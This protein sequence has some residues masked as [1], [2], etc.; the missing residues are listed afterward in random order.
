M[1]MQ[2]PKIRIVLLCTCLAVLTPISHADKSLK[3]EYKHSGPRE[4]ARILKDQGDT[5]ETEYRDSGKRGN[6]TKS[7]HPGREHQKKS[8]KKSDT[9]GKVFRSPGQR[10]TADKDR[11]H[12]ERRDS[13]GDR[14]RYKHSPTTKALPKS[15]TRTEKERIARE[16]EYRKR[17]PYYPRPSRSHERHYKSYS[18]KLRN[19]HHYHNH[20]TYHYHTHY[21]APIHHHYHPIGYRV[22]YLPRTYISIFIGGFPYFYFGGVFYRH[23]VD[24]YIVVRAPIGAVVNVLPIGFI[25]FYVGGFTYYYVNDTYYAWD[26]DL[27][28]YVVVAKPSGAEKAIAEATAGRLYVYPKQGQNEEQQASDRYE[29]HRWAVHQTD[30]DPSL[31]EPGEISLSD[32]RKYKRAITACLEGRGYSVK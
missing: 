30:V 32:Q 27:D 20:E 5:S 1:S 18:H 26:D 23:H 8:Y 3:E 13:S 17:H 15:R 25:S 14:D 10:G 19:K 28:G 29:C 2:I 12:R 22:H 7:D 24:G 11:E 6:S 4:K 21:L 31:A 16:K 9:S